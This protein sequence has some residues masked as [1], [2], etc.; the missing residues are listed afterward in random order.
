MILQRLF[1]FVIG[2]FFFTSAAFAFSFKHDDITGFVDTTLSTGI[3]LRVEDRNPSLIG[4]ANGGQAFSINGD[5]GNLNYSRGSV[6]NNVSKATHDLGLSYQ[7][8]TAFMRA[9]YFYDALND[10]KKELTPEER[11]GAGRD[12]SLLDAYVKS[13]W[14]PAQKPV[15]I[16]VGRQVLNWGESTFIGNG[17][18]VINTY[19]LTKLRGAG[20]EVRE[21]LL[22]T[23]MISG[24]IEIVPDLT[25]ESFYLFEFDRVKGD[26]SGTF[27]ST[28]DITGEHPSSVLTSGFGLFAGG[29]PGRVI[30]RL[31]DRY[32][33]DSG[34]FGLALHY[35]SRQLSSTEFSL[36]F[37]NYHSRFPILSAVATSS[38]AT[39][40]YFAEYPED[41]QLY[42]GGFNT[43][44]GN[45]GISFQGEYTFRPKQPLQIDA[46]EI[47]A[48]SQFSSLSQLQPARAAGDVIHGSKRFPTSQ[49][50][51][52]LG[53]S[54]GAANPFWADE[55]LVLSEAALVQ[56][57]HFPEESSLRFEAPGTNLP[58]ITGFGAP[59]L[60]TNN[61]WAEEFSWGYV[62]AS[63]LTYNRVFNDVNLA[64]RIA[65]S[66]NVNGT[67]PGPGGNFV[68]GRMTLTTG[69]T[70]S[71]LDRW[72]AEI[73][74]TSY[75]GASDRNTSSDRD[76]LSLSMKVYF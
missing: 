74:Y 38:P 73:S 66:H 54:F 28:D 29:T 40:N 46:L 3:T 57:H 35:L 60:Q 33:K 51:G 34:Q 64:P 16:R 25:L 67:S 27:F 61:A 8:V 72:A 15:D 56:V 70:A 76:F 31:A 26:V 43:E 2:S 55:W 65:F 69:V 41:I 4:I 32:A 75:W 59:Q 30:P 58:A 68:E 47:L 10:N 7:N 37:M 36:Y 24:S 13:T 11:R 23:S 62:I 19:D 9:S 45:T 49:L 1:L 18:N 50:Q 5:D 39:P 14:E 42:G 12:F 44:L 22:P 63:Q 6:V 71:Y 17:V 21:A 20:A 53:K 52:T 48:A